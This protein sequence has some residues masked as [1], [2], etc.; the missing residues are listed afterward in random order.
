MF[1]SLC[2][3]LENAT[4]SNSSEDGQKL[5]KIA[6]EKSLTD[7]L[8]SDKKLTFMPEPVV[9]RLMNDNLAF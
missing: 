4:L 9:C 6:I 2:K 8:Q 5:V 3:I 7:L 1:F